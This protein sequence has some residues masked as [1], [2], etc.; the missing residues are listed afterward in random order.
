MKERKAESAEAE[1]KRGEG[2]GRAE[3]SEFRLG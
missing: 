1:G 3:T 2:K